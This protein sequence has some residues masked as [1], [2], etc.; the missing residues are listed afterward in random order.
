MGLE[1]RE[2]LSVGNDVIDSDHK[3][4]IEIINQVERS[5]G[6]KDRSKLM[7]ALDSLSQYSEVH[8]D[9]EEKIASAVGYIPVPH[10]HQSHG[11]LLIKLDKIKQGIGEE[12]SESTADQLIAF[13]RSWL[14]D[15]LLKEDMLLKPALKKYPPDFNPQNKIR[16]EKIQAPARPETSPENTEPAMKS[17]YISWKKESEL[18]IPILDEQ[19][20][21]IVATINSLFYFIQK[22]RGIDA[23]RPTLNVL[24]QYTKIHFEAEEE[25]I[26]QE[27]YPGFDAHV[28]LH[29]ELER[30]MSNVMRESVSR[31]DPTMVLEFLREWWMNHINQQD[32]EYAAYLSSKSQLITG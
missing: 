26:K 6:A 9:R 11:A 14:V 23:L 20:R 18:G 12:W 21:A 28:L 2:Q 4:L 8:F 17:L 16:T 5:F 29:Q 32:R 13:L 10:L 15:H 3:R 19:H 1:W 27:G 24:D 7:L 30:K 31:G 22:G 25:L